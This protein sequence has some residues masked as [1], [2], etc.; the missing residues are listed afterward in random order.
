M[1]RWVCEERKGNIFGCRCVC[2]CV[3]VCVRRGG[4]TCWGQVGVSGGEGG[5]SCW[6]QVGVEANPCK[7]RLGVATSSWLHRW[8]SGA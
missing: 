4:S 7:G 6:G 5:C 2:V 3:C 8:G 1:G